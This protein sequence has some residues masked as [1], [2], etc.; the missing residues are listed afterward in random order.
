[1]GWWSI[2]IKPLKHFGREGLVQR[3]ERIK[4]ICHLKKRRQSVITDGSLT[5]L[6]PAVKPTVT[7]GNQ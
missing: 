5:E 4:E 1:M 6:L 3:E 2:G 7:V